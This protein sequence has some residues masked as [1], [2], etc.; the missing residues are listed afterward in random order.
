MVAWA[1]IVADMGCGE[2][3]LASSLP[4]KVHSFDLGKER[5][6]VGQILFL[7]SVL[8]IEMDNKHEVSLQAVLRSRSWWSRNY[9]GTWS[10]SRK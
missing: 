3:R 10:R 5:P 7:V 2:A 6:R 4:N 9:F 1:A 8:V